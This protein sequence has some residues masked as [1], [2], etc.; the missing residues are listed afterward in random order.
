MWNWRWL[1]LKWGLGLRFRVCPLFKEILFHFGE[2]RHYS[3]PVG[4]QTCC[5]KRSYI[6][7]WEYCSVTSCDLEGKRLKFR[8]YIQAYAYY[9]YHYDNGEYMTVLT[10]QIILCR[11]IKYFSILIRCKFPVWLVI[12]ATNSLNH[13]QRYFIKL[14]CFLRFQSM[15]WTTEISCHTSVI[16]KTFRINW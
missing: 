10:Y 8:S 11:P 14:L 15:S 7:T 16:Q 12:V 5:R 6:I 9:P 1:I 4:I 3:K 13:T 2:W